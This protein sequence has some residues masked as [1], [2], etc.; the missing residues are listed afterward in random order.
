MQLLAALFVV[1]ASSVGAQTYPDRALRIIIP[2]G[3][4]GGFDYLG[5]VVAPKLSERLGQPVVVENRP[6][7]GN[8][9]GTEAVAKA[10]HDGYMLLVGGVTNITA[11]GGGVDFKPVS[12]PVIY[13]FCLLARKD[14]PQ[15]SLKEVVESARANPNKLTYASTGMATLQHV[16]GAMLAYLNGVTLLHVPYKGAAAAQQDL[17]AGR[18]DLFFNNCG[19]IK[20]FVD[21]GQLKLLALSGRERSSAFPDVPTIGETG[22]A[23]HEIESWLGFFV[24]ARTPQAIVERLR[25]DLAM[26]VASPDVADRLARDGGRLLR[27]SPAESETFVQTEVAKWRRM[28]LNAGVTE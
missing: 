6:G 10:P 27:M 8:L 17:L 24:G 9:V 2:V 23:P 5:R 28:L 18:V 21:S 25:A 11:Y 3:P 16:S 19:V 4:G 12:I 14:L 15:S 1:Y 13:P 26:A 7:A 20:Q 22:V